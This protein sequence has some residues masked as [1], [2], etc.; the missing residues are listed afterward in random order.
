MIIESSDN[1]L[2]RISRKLRLVPEYEIDAI[3]KDGTG[4]V[5]NSSILNYI[6]R[7]T[8]TEIKKTVNTYFPTVKINFIFFIITS[9][10]LRD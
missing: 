10:P 5:E 2:S 9:S 7:W 1:F 4:G 8:K 6:Y 3:L